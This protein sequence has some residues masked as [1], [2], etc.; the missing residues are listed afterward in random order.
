MINKTTNPHIVIAF[1]SFN[2]LSTNYTP[3]IGKIYIEIL[4]KN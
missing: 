2:F 4:Q 1:A 3:G